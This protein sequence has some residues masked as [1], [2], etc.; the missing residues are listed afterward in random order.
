MEV[1]A[2]QPLTPTGG[3]QQKARCTQTTGP[4]ARAIAALMSGIFAR[5]F[6]APAALSLAT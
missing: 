3:S 1:M 6:S 4:P 5:T 2:G